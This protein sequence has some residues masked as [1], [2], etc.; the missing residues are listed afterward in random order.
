MAAKILIVDDAPDFVFAVRNFLEDLG[1]EVVEAYD[2]QEALQ[3][4]EREQ[5]DLVLLDV[6]MPIMDGW[7]TLS[8]IRKRPGCEDLPVVM[9]TGLDQP[10]HIAESYGRGCTDFVVKQATD[11]DQLALVIERL[12]Q[13]SRRSRG[14]A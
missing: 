5:P 2:G 14:G 12:L 10:Q 4:I 13:I 8:A 3:V 11:Y 6:I 7:E 1:Y 9:L